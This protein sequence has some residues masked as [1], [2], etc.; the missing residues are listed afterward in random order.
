[1][2]RNPYVRWTDRKVRGDPKYVARRNSDSAVVRYQTLLY[3]HG[4]RQA[5]VMNIQATGGS[6]SMQYKDDFSGAKV[7]VLAGD[8]LLVKLRD[9]LNTIP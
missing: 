4:I 1:M 2:R 5:Y 8:D 7:A 6:Q 3:N 9:D